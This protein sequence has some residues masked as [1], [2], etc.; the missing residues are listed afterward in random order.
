MAIL[1]QDTFNRANSTTIG[2]ATTG[3]A[4]T[5]YVAATT[6]RWG[7]SSNQALPNRLSWDDPT[8]INVGQADNLAYQITVA[9]YHAQ[10]QIMWRIGSSGRNYFVLQANEVYRVINDAWVLMGTVTAYTSGAIIRIE[11][12]GN[13]HKV[14]VN[15]TQRL[16]FT[17]ATHNT[18]TRFG[19]GANSTTCRYD[20]YLVETL[21]VDTTPPAEVPTLTETHTHNSVTLNWT[22][23]SD[24]DFSHVRI[25]RDGTQ[26]ATNQTGLTYTDSGLNASTAYTYLVKSVDALGNESAGKTLAVTTSAPPDTTPPANVTNLTATPTSNSVTLNWTNPPD[27]DFSFI[28]LE[29]DN[30]EIATN[31]HGQTY[32]DTGL[33]EGTT[34]VYSLYAVDTNGNGSSGASVTVTT[35]TTA[36]PDLTPPSV[37]IIGTD[38]FKV[39]DE[40]GV[41]EAKIRFAFDRDVV[42]WQMRVMGVD[43]FTGIFADGGE[44]VTAN[45]PIE[46]VVSWDELYQEGHNRVNIYG[47]S[48]NG[49]WTSYGNSL[50]IDGG[51]FLNVTFVKSYQGG[52]FL[53]ENSN[54]LIDGGIF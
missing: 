19:F 22:K 42:E 26:I 44:A 5:A 29:R 7:I 15:G 35:T 13:I 14:F 16:Q 12:T 45:T 41:S 33:A 52:T 4:W 24:T 30:V 9:T 40:T 11:L 46:A 37:R 10:N 28:S 6:L 53:N 36:L 18:A 34:Y 27:P 17:D 23:P 20:N 54:R 32:Q 39:S 31:L 21:A 2:T 49:I 50:Y 8:F 3:Q 1:A 47:K 51:S 38:R 25:L 48:I 43:P